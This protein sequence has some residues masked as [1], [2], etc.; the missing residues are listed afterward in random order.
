VK[1]RAN[2]WHILP[3]KS[4]FSIQLIQVGKHACIHLIKIFKIADLTS[5]GQPDT[6]FQFTQSGL[7]YPDF[8]ADFLP[9]QIPVSSQAFYF[10][11]EFA[12]W[13][14]SFAAQLNLALFVIK[15]NRFGCKD[16][17]RIKMDYP[18]CRRLVLSA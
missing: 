2:W 15:Q 6:P 5:G 18:P 11:S 10:F 13:Q 16:Y 12:H 3:Y 17:I 8:S 9:G 7:G 14:R 4:L 1:I